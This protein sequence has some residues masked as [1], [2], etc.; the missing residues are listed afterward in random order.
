MAAIWSAL[1]ALLHTRAWSSRP[2]KRFLAPGSPPRTNAPAAFHAA[3]TPALASRFP[4][5]DRLIRS[6]PRSNVP[7]TI[8]HAPAC[9]TEV[10]VAHRVAAPA[11]SDGFIPNAHRLLFFA[12]RNTKPGVLTP[13]W[14]STV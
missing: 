3:G 12:Y 10:P 4:F 1:S 6:A 9:G 5:T 7:V 2:L 8:V 13:F 14:D 11:V